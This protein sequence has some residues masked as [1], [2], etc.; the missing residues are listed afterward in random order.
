MRRIRGSITL[1]AA[2]LLSIVIS[3]ILLCVLTLQFSLMGDDGTWAHYDAA[4]AIKA[5]ASRGAHGELIIDEHSANAAKVTPTLSGFKHDFPGFWYVVS[6]GRSFIQYGPVPARVLAGL[7]DEQKQT[8]FSGYAASTSSMRL[9]RSAI[10][11]QTDAGEV[12]IE[13]GGAAY[14]RWQIF[15]GTMTDSSIITIPILIVL[16]GTIIAA[17]II[18]PL[19]IARPVRRVATAAELIDG[20]R[21]GARLP[22][23]GAPSEL[24]PMVS[25]FN[26]ALERIDVTTS[27]QRRF[28]SNAAHELRTPLARVRT[29]LEGVSDKALKTALV[30]ELQSLSSTVTMLLQL[31]RLSSGPAEEAEI[32]LVAAAKRVAAEHAPS[33]LAFGVEI[34]FSAPAEAIKTYGSEQAVRIALANIIHNAVQHSRQG[35]QILVEAC[36]P[37]TVR[38]IDHGPGISPGARSAVLQ[39]FVRGRT[40]GNG[41]GL[42]LA[43]VAQVMALHKGLAAIDDT[44]NGGTTIAL[45]FPPI[46]APTMPARDREFQKTGG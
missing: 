10:V 42:G 36:L 32:D 30:T 8:S 11:S 7:A 43:I 29:R 31:A 2:A 13:L 12:L 44:P 4:G 39:P 34:E 45:T 19:L 23:K 5:A 25:A 6:D 24:I 16:I 15:I 17:I 40:D 38:V 28:L 22:E 9:A 18:V 14:N 46:A 27:A 21:E 33:A 26:R 41:T 37:A 3:A 35:Q 20:T 1:I